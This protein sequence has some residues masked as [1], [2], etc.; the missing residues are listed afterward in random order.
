MRDGNAQ[1]YNN[2][3]LAQIKNKNI[4]EAIKA[5][6]KSLSME[7]YNPVTHSNLG[8]A[9]YFNKDIEKATYEWA[10]VGRLDPEYALKR[11][12]IETATYD[13]TQA[14]V[15]MIDFQSYSLK[16]APEYSNSPLKLIPAE[17]PDPWMIDTQDKDLAVVPELKQKINKIR[18]ATKMYKMY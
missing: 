18:K 11:R 10:T 4:P 17:S 12:N 2:L 5:F 3:A 6:E 8:L 13:D 14:A 16:L 7:P 9:Y 15:P 1:D